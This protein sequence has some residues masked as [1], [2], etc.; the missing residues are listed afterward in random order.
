[1]S[2]PASIWMIR[3][4]LFFAHPIKEEDRQRNL[5]GVLQFVGVPANARR[6]IAKSGIAR[7]NCRTPRALARG[8]I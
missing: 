2:R 3:R 7:W 5:V 4:S 6:G 8:H 1:M